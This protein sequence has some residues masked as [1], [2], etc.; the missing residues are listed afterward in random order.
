MKEV[1]EIVHKISTTKILIGAFIS[2][3]V[4]TLSVYGF[5]QKQKSDIILIVNTA[6]QPIKTDMQEVKDSIYKHG[7]YIL[8]IKHSEAVHEIKLDAI[9]TVIINDKIKNPAATKEDIYNILN[10]WSESEKKNISG[11]TLPR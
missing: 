7:A 9:K 6:V 5:F 10:V 1:D 8:S 3:V 4:M 2:V 11:L